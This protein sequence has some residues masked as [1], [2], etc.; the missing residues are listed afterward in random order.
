MISLRISA[1]K[2][3]WVRNTP[4]RKVYRVILNDGREIGIAEIAAKLGVSRSTLFN[5]IMGG[6]MGLGTYTRE[7]HVAM[8]RAK[9]AN[10][11]FSKTV[12]CPHCKG[13]G[14]VQRDLTTPEG[15]NAASANGAA[16]AE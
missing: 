11:V 10:R 14:R 6:G 7:F 9:A 16:A 15:I 3:P 4:Q 12:K 8:A 1:P 5:E 2:R 13:R